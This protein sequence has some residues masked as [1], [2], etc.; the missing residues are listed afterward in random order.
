MKNISKIIIPVILSITLLFNSISVKAEETKQVDLKNK[1]IPLKT[2]KAGNGF[3]DLN[4]LQEIL[5]DKKIVAMGEATH[6]TKE[7]F[8]M[9]HRMFEFLVE[10]M[11]YRIFAIE[12]EFG[13]CQDINDYVLN[14][15]GTPDEA[16]SYFGM[17]PWTTE[18][19]LDMLKWMRTYNENPEHKRKIKF[20]GYDMQNHD[21][22]INKVLD[23]IKKVENNDYL[24]SV[25]LMLEDINPDIKNYY[26]KD[27][28]NDIKNDIEKLKT[29]FEKSK[30]RYVKRTSTWEYELVHQNLNL[31]TQSVGLSIISKKGTSIDEFNFR[32]FCMA[33]NVKWILDYEKQFGNDKIMLWAHN[34]HVSRKYGVPECA[35]KPMGG[36]LKEIFNDNYYSIGFDFYEGSFRSFIPGILSLANFNIKNSPQDSM[37]YSFEKTGVPLSFMDFKSAA[38]DKSIAAWLSQEQ[39]IH[40]VGAVYLGF[41]ELTFLPQVPM[42]CF[43]GLIFVKQTSAAVGTAEFT[44]LI[45]NGDIFIRIFYFIIIAGI[46]AI[47]IFC[48]YKLIKRIKKRKMKKE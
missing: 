21:K 4:I 44:T 20:Y 3:E 19:V 17:W 23:Y 8:E 24:H 34:G 37:A 10:K 1:A 9:K 43:D 16:I 26:G 38:E 25:E 14:G 30:E 18:E 35:L 7:F 11:D 6:G 22:D 40:N 13:D 31:I 47:I 29:E 41:P 48:I 28:L 39:F 27:K 2:T 36:N 32:D 46:L 42:E 5:K 33:Q 12:A 15:S 45:L